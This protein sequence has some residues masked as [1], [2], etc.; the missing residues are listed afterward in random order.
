VARKAGA[1]FPG[2]RAGR[3]WAGTVRD[4]VLSPWSELVIHLGWQPPTDTKLAPVA[5]Q[6]S[7][8]PASPHSKCHLLCE[9]N[10]EREGMDGERGG[11][12]GTAL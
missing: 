3:H 5:K 4:R 9:G 7:C 8:A 12:G 10:G 6:R 1:G 2:A 11:E